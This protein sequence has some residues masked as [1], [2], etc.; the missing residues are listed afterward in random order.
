MVG[1]KV[2]V[3]GASG[4]LGSALVERLTADG[5]SVV[6]LVRPGSRTHAGP[7]AIVWDPQGGATDRAALADARIDA[8]VHLAGENIARG[9]WTRERKA[10]IRESR[11]DGTRHLAELLAELQPR[12][13]TLVCASAIGYYGDRGDELLDEQTAPGKGFLPEVCRAWEAAADPA[14]AAGIRVV[15]LR[16]GIV[17][18]P[19]GG[20]LAQMLP[21][22]KLGLGGRLGSGRQ[23]MS[24][25]SRDDVIGVIRHAL[26][27]A[28]LT[29][30]VNTVAPGAVTNLEFT[31]T[32]AR[33]LGRPAF[34]PVPAA[35]IRLLFGEMGEALLLESTRVLPARL[36]AVGYNFAH[37]ELERGLRELFGRAGR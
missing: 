21:P 36:R 16:F 35:A 6:P 23:F 37:P 30:P 19:A 5:H 7:P 14:R 31:H 11:V 32:L 20:A 24:W 25:V 27:N 29:G 1:M 10:K 22:F 12:P 17:L 2:A 18:H 3:T 34:L 9:R 8:V 26:G 33:V 13:E 15:H 4:F 28:A